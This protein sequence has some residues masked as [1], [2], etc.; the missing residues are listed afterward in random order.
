MHAGSEV[1]KSH[2][3]LAVAEC[4]G[5]MRMQLDYDPSAAPAGPVPHIYL[6]VSRRLANMSYWTFESQTIAENLGPMRLYMTTTVEDH[7]CKASVNV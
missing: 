7:G 6:I 1:F 4:T 5:A 3:S 2:N